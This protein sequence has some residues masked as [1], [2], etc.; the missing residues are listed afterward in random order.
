MQEEKKELQKQY[1]ELFGKKPSFKWSAEELQ[2]KIDN[3]GSEELAEKDDTVFK[4]IKID[5]KRRYHFRLKHRANPQTFL[6]REAKVWDEEAEK[7]RTIRLCSVE[8]S[9]YID[10]QQ[11]DA[12]TDATAAVFIDGNLYI[13]GTEAN[14]IKFVLAFDGYDKKKTILPMSEDLRDMYE[15]VDEEKL[16]LANL[17][18]EEAILDAKMLIK[19]AKIGEIRNFMRSVFLLGVDQM[20]DSDVKTSA[21]SSAETNPYIFLNEF[22]NP[23]HEV[24]A[25]IQKLFGLQLLIEAEGSVRWADNGGVILTYNDKKERADDALAKFVILGDK[26]AK[27]FKERM[28]SKLKN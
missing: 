24:K 13:N 21:Y 2:S 25:N 5:P 7:T 12:H 18:K 19:T 16:S 6:P 8:S 23:I 22:T 4:G 1:E 3:A 15:L 17:N 11:E 26:P 14:K 27:E 20:N 10:E 9:P 28:E